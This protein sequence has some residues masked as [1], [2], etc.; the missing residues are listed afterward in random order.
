MHFIYCFY[1]QKLYRPMIVDRSLSIRIDGL[2]QPTG[3]TEPG[4]PASWTQAD[5]TM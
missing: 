3:G 1:L 2:F 5:L 4:W